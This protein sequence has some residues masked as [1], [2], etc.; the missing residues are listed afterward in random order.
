MEK[1][2]IKKKEEKENDKEEKEEVE[3]QNV[4]FDWFVF[5]YFPIDR[6]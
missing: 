1:E 3:E 6:N 2:K 5:R 4:L